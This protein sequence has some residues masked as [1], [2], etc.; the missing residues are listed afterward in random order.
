MKTFHRI[1]IIKMMVKKL[2]V[3]LVLSGVF[4]SSSCEPKEPQN[5]PINR[6]DKLT[7]NNVNGILSPMA[8]P[9][10]LKYE[11]KYYLYGTDDVSPDVDKGFKVYVS[12]DMISWGK[13]QG[14]HADGRALEATNSW[15][16]WGFWGAEVYER[17]GIFY[18]YYTVEEHI[19]IATS[20]SPLGPFTQKDNKPLRDK[21]EI[22]PH[23]FVDDDGKAYM[24]YVGFDNNANEIFVEEMQDDW[25]STKSETRTRCIWWTQEWENKDPDYA[26][27]P[28]TEGSA[29]LKHKGTYYLFYTGNHFLSPYYAVGYATAKSPFGPW[30]KYENNPVL[31]QTPNLKGTGHCS[32][33]RAPNYDLYIAYHAHKDIKTVLPRK[34]CFDKCE[35]IPNPDSSKPDILKVYGPTQTTQEVTWE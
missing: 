27:W 26:S 17:N 19:A 25:L 20:T 28:V 34:L 23:L 30:E 7:Y 2:L 35:F 18:M 14:V 4:C 31:V 16:N 29:V 3:F 15:G 9:F 22:D 6:N 12:S 24:Y 5:N 13:A 11:D 8:D 1:Q 32:F 21:R 10:I 33:V